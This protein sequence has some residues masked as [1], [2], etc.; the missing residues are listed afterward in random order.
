MLPRTHSFSSIPLRSN[1]RQRGRERQGET[2]IERERERKKKREREE[3]RGREGKERQRY[4]ER[5][6]YIYMCVYLPS[7]S[8]FLPF[9]SS[10]AK[11]SSG[12]GTV[13]VNSPCRQR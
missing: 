8:K 10:R 2:P 13:I 3:E 11:N 4:E 7:G 5:E 12:S 6:I 1:D 9:I